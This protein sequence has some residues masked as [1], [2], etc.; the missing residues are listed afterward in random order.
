MRYDPDQCAHCGSLP[1]G[2]VTS[3]IGL[4]SAG[5]FSDDDSFFFCSDKCAIV[6]LN[7][8]IDSR[9]AIGKTID[10]DAEYNRLITDSERYLANQLPPGRLHSNEEVARVDQLK[11]KELAN[12]RRFGNWWHDMRDASFS[13]AL[14]KVRAQFAAQEHSARETEQSERYQDDHLRLLKM[15]ADGQIAQTKYETQRHITE[16]FAEIDERELQ[17]RIVRR[18]IPDKI[19]YEHTH[20]L[21]PSGS[22]KTTLIQDLILADLAQP[23][24]P[25][26]VIIDPKGLMVERISKL[27]IFADRLKDRLVIVDPTHEPLPALNMFEPPPKGTENQVISNFAFIFSQAGVPFTGKM[28]PVFMFAVR[29]MFT[30]PRA[31]LFTF[32]DLFD[33]TAKD[34]KFQPYIDRLPDPAAQRFFAN[35]FYASNYADTKPQV[36]SRLYQ[37]ISRPELVAMF[38]APESKLDMFDC[39]QQR[40]IVLVN[41]GLMKLGPTGSQLLGR[42][43]ISSTLNA[44]YRRSLIPRSQ[45]TAA[46]LYIDEFQDFADEEKTPELLRLA[47]EYNLGVVLA[48]QNMH[49][50]E[51]NDSLRTTISTNT[52]IKYCSSPEASDQSYMA[53]DL[54]CDT[55]FLKVHT[56]TGTFA[57]FA[58]GMGLQHPFLTTVEFGNIEQQPQMSDEAHS[59]V[60][61][62][63]KTFLAAS[64]THKAPVGALHEYGWSPAVADDQPSISQQETKLDDRHTTKP[65]TW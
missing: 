17:E 59:P 43:V 13:A 45:W 36:K 21:G 23:D 62:N 14:Q 50:N 27:A 15:D 56:T 6:E 30:I 28:L 39:L 46:Y 55:D 49:C 12:L 22:G 20:I 26:I 54:R 33:D 5:K 57:T 16:V 61:S 37:I 9:F 51:L 3:Q 4:T 29:L 34:R 58:R 48:H 52:S 18:D 63:A 32:M 64:E 7:R 40:K 65:T 41:T 35:D 2:Y 53:R 25:A 31:N 24:P 42:F 8:Q 60:I 38:N 19:R 44:A 11:E 10:D 47:R 1:T